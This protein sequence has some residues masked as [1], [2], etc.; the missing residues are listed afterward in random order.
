M[1]KE[2]LEQANKLFA[3]YQLDT[4]IKDNKMFLN[5]GNIEIEISKEEI[6]ARANQ[7]NNLK[8]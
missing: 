4:F 8:Q 2:T 3:L 1:K 5:L 6:K 7:Y